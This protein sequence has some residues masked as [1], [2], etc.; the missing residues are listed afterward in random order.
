MGRP[1][2]RATLGQHTECDGICFH[3][4]VRI[5]YSSRRIWKIRWRLTELEQLVFVTQTEEPLTGNRS[6]LFGGMKKRRLSHENAVMIFL[7]LIA[8]KVDNIRT[9]VVGKMID[10]V[11]LQ[12]A[13]RLHTKR[14]GRLVLLWF[15][16]TFCKK[17]YPRFMSLEHSK[18]KLQVI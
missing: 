4:K 10:K 3:F 5:S 17:N 6:S 16:S 15:F 9:P 12:R 11:Y 14:T 1:D 7:L 13:L 2:P 18:T 8:R